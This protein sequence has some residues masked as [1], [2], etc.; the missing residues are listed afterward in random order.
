MFAE[1][2][3]VDPSTLSCLAHGGLCLSKSMAKRKKL[4]PPE[5]KVLVNHILEQADCGFP[6]TY[7]S[8]AKMANEIQAACLN[9]K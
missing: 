7:I 9:G 4:S 8:V 6:L 3:G 1:K 5:E 2:N